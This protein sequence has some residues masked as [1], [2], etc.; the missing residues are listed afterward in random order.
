MFRTINRTDT[1]AGNDHSGGSTRRGFLRSAAVAGAVTALPAADLLIAAPAAQAA[2]VAGVKLPAASSDITRFQLRVP[3]SALNDL[4]R[5]LASVRLPE[6]ET[7]D[8]VSQGVPLSRLRNLIEYWRTGYDWRDLEN[9]L[10]EAGQY[11]T[12]IDGLG[13][14]FLH[15]R[16][17]HPNALPVILNHGWPGS[18]VEFLDVIGPLTDPTR[19]GGRAEDAFHVVIP[20]MP[21]YGFSDRPA[22]TGWDPARIASAWIELM[23]RLGY[24]R[25]IA[26]GGD[27]GGAVT[28]QMAKQNPAGLIGVHL[29]LPEFMLTGTALGNSTPEEQAAIA[30]QQAYS[31][32]YAG[33]FQEQA[34]RPQT[35]G[36]ALADSPSGQAAWIFEKFIDWT[37]SN[38]QP[39][40]AFGFDRMLDDISVYWLTGTGASSARLYWEFYRDNHDLTV[41]DQP[42][43]VSVFPAELVRTPKVWAEKAYKNLVY[44]NDDIAAGGH[45]AAFEQPAIFANELRAYARLVR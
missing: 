40:R 41:L 9:R 32:Q 16:S 4:R 42:V 18:F 36:Y 23:R 35:I 34:T 5:R 1:P 3:Q 30:Q 13:I 45:F 37:D 31:A 8:D 12:Q 10:N 44:F 21:G 15:V 2:T 22:D 7:V 33:Y 6:R 29:N 27:W 11:R 39:E 25:Y 19:Y 20:S 43:G 28:T 14:H 17:K 26:Q 24:D 38:H